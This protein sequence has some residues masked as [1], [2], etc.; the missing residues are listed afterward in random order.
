M[1][2]LPRH[3]SILEYLPKGSRRKAESLTCAAG[4]ARSENTRRPQSEGVPIL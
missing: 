2:A 4:I 1:L 3:V